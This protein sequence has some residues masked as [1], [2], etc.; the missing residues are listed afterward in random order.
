[1]NL[2]SPDTSEEMNRSSGVSAQQERCIASQLTC[3]G[4]ISK[5]PDRSSHELEHGSVQL[6]EIL[7]ELIMRC[8]ADEE[9]GLL[10]FAPHD[11]V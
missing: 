9:I 11:I 5:E 6:D 10:D 4:F 2:A 1:M 3:M 7:F 8:I